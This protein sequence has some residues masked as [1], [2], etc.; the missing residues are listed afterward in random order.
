MVRKTARTQQTHSEK[1]ETAYHFE[2]RS[3][4]QSDDR[5]GGLHEENPSIGDVT[6][7][8]A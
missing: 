7:Q 6:D 4:C 3:S 2:A 5:V 8:F 1:R